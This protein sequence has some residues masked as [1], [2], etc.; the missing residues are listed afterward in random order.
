[1]NTDAWFGACVRVCIGCVI[2]ALVWTDHERDGDGHGPGL[3]CSTVMGG[4]Y[5]PIGGSFS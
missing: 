2:D 5:I 1:M 3:L 4:E